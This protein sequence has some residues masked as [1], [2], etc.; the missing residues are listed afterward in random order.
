M[1]VF[2]VSCLQKSLRGKAFEGVGRIE[3][4]ATLQ[5]LQ[6]TERPTRG[7][8]GSGRASGISLKKQ[9][10]LVQKGSIHNEGNVSAVGSTTSVRTLSDQAW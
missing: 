8:C 1:L 3:S 7:A 5:L 9:K 4:D 2:P 6:I 10:G